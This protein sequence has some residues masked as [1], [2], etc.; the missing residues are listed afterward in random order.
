MSTDIDPKWGT[1]SL[2]HDP[3]ILA[4]FCARGSDVLIT[5]APK[6]GTTWMQQILYQ[7]KSKGDV[8]FTAIDDVVPWLELP[9][10]TQSWQQRLAQYDHMENPRI[11]KTHCT[12]EQTPGS[13]VANIVLTSRDPRDCC[14]SFYHHVM[15]L[16]DTALNYFDMKRPTSFDDY[17]EHWLT[18]GSWFRNVK[19]WW[20]HINDHNVMWLRY[21]DMVTDLETSIRSL[22]KFLC[23]EIDDHQMPSIVTHC[24]LGW[25]KQHSD[26]FVT[27]F[28]SGE[29]MFK[30]GKFIR[31]G[32]VGDHKNLL[33]PQQGQRILDKVYD[34]LPDDCVAFLGL[35]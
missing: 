18:T 8:S 5:T 7:L 27:R 29:S 13:D 15:S 11:F 9:R 4:H 16:T 2:L 34:E 17:F 6:A 28:D 32:R 21:E 30:T 31:K 1:P 25:M 20:P 10:Q 14:I 24:S 33:S 23:W 22:V 3:D 19:S 26:K 35:D 12:Y